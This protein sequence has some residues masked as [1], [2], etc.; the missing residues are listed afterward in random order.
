MAAGLVRGCAEVGEMAR[1]WGVAKHA[2]GTDDMGSVQLPGQ[3]VPGRAAAR[4]RM[5][6]ACRFSFLHATG[7][8]AAHA[9]EEI[10]GGGGR[11]AWM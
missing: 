11:S 1:G 4:T 3:H 7:R 6:W 9:R 2:K 5:E 8:R 10:W